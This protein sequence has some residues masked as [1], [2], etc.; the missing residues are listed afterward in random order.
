[1]VPDTRLLLNFVHS[2]IYEILDK[3]SPYKY[4]YAENLIEGQYQKYNNN[5]GWFNSN[6]N[7]SSL[8]S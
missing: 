2:F 7:E 1:V 3:K 5:D 6:V 4:Y 8:I